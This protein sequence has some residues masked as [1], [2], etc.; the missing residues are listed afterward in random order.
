M[1]ISTDGLIIMEQ[2]IGESDR[3]V[4]VLT[5]QEGLVRAFVRGAKSMKNRNTSSTQLLCYSRLSIYQGRDKYIIDEAE[6]QEVFFELRRDIEKLSLA[7]Y[8][9]ELALALAPVNGEAGDFLRL[10]L[11]ALYFL[12]HEKRPPALIKSVVEMRMLALAGYMPN[13]I[14]CAECGE[15]E[16]EHMCF[17]PKMGVL[18][19]EQCY[20]DA[21]IFGGI[22]MGRGVTTALRHTIYADFDKIF[23]FS[24]PEDGQ[25]VLSLASE[26]YILFTV[27][28]SFQTLEFYHRICSKQL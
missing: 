19:C 8:F 18:Y 20:K 22:P 5:R 11:N 24:L 26:E 2:N 13:L 7:Q 28:H 21:Q 27:E 12:A 25:K 16:K 15:Y 9:C 6:P 17:V 23:S 14:N 4:T 3:L 1:Q 10:M